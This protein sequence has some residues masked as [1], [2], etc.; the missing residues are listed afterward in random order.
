MYFRI[1]VYLFLV[2]MRTTLKPSMLTVVLLTQSP[3]SFK[4]P[5]ISVRDG[6]KL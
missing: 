2:A 1:I 3:T 6:S 5:I 4:P